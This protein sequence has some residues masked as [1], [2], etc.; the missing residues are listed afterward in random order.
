MS[1]PGSDATSAQR[2]EADCAEE[3]LRLLTAALEE[4]RALM[5]D[6]TQ[7]SGKKRDEAV[8]GSACALGA[9]V[10]P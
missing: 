10:P 7:Y 3:P 8:C 4:L 6:P 5:T 2:T 1:L 9:C